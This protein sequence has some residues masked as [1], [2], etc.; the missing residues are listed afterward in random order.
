MHK[1]EYSVSVRSSQP[2]VFVNYVNKPTYSKMF[3][4]KKS[5]DSQQMPQGVVSAD[6][7]ADLSWSKTVELPAGSYAFVMVGDLL[8]P[9][10]I[11]LHL[12]IAVDGVEKASDTM[13][14]AS[15]LSKDYQLP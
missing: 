4:V 14:D 13:Q 2:T 10:H 6:G 8:G 7:Q 15:F 11:N 3:N 1:V 12:S 9:K 5:S